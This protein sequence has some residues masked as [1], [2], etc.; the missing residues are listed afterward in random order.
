MMFSRSNSAGMDNLEFLPTVPDPDKWDNGVMGFKYQ[1]SWGMSDEKFKIESSIDS[2]LSDY[3]EPQQITKDYLYKAKHF[4]TDL[5]SF[6]SQD[7]QKWQYLGHS[8]E[9]SWHMTTVCVRRISEEILAMCGQHLCLVLQCPG[10]KYNWY[11]PIT[12]I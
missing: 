12:Y 1:I 3:P 11:E 4:V 7:F 10:P 9:D 2:I 8:K 6:I 5:C